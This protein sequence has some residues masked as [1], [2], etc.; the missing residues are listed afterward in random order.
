MTLSEQNS[1]RGFTI[2]FIE[3]VDNLPKFN[4]LTC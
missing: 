3:K 4:A 2:D 1:F